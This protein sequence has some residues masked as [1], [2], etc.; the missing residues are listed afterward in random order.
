MNRYAFRKLFLLFGDV[1]CYY[2]ALFAALAI[3]TMEAPSLA[4]WADHAAAYSLLLPLWLIIFY[5]ADFYHLPF[6]FQRSAFY[7]RTLI[8]MGTM[9]V[10]SVVLFYIL[11]LSITPKTVLFIHGS[12]FT[13]LF[14]GWRS[15]AAWKI[16]AI[17][18][19]TAIFIGD[20]SHFSSLRE[21]MRTRS[22]G[23][24]FFVGYTDAC[25]QNV[26]SNDSFLSI[27][28]IKEH[29]SHKR[30]DTLVVQD[31]RLGQALALFHTFLIQG[32]TIQTLS[33]FFEE[34]FQE[35]LLGSLDSAGI[36][37]SVDLAG[38]KIYDRGKRYFDIIAAVIL[39]VVGGSIA[40]PVLAIV[41]VF[42]RAPLLY[43]Q[44]RCT[45]GGKIF[46]LY[47]FRTMVPDAEK[48]GAVW[49]EKNDSRITRIGRFLRYTHIDE[50]PQIWNV[51]RGDLS[52]VG[53]RPERPDFVQLL[54]EAIPYYALRHRV[55]PGI[56]GWAQINFPY[57]ASVEDA[58]RKLSYDLYYIK[59]RS[60]TL[61]LKIFLKTIAFLM[62]GE[63]G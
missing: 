30:V 9:M 59:H 5:I 57:A 22:T 2:V 8:V 46:V 17:E 7:S 58:R 20:Q 35:V 3:R 37:D 43:R 6:L 55:M 41:K 63:G 36:A 28:D 48:N 40:I 15:I 16:G 18:K 23:E 42:Y 39:L 34:Q 44:E 49:A 26:S 54:D 27:S 45:K 29:M 62:K 31:N 47:K 53:P 19:K 21:R 4:V 52:F 10:L 11:S 25:E 33:A 56:S 61:D 38:R 24:H 12:V 32:G 1:V 51:L 60:L 13:L 50:L 14:L